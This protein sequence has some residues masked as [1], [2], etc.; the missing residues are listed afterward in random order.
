[1]T[2]Q[3][4]LLWYKFLKKYPAKIMRQRIVG[5]YI[6]DFYC[7]KSKLIIELDGSQHF[8]ENNA[9]YDKIRTDYFNSLGLKVIRFTNYEIKYNFDSVCILIDSEIKQR[10]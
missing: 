7:S 5:N 8:E 3:E 10:I 9:E 4:G 2:P 1:M 6:V